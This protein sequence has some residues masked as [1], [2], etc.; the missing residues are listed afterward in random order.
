MKEAVIEIADKDNFQTLVKDML[1]PKDTGAKLLE[2]I[3]VVV[4]A[5][6][7]ELTPEMVKEMIEKI[8]HEHLGWLVVWGG[9]F[10]GIIGLVSVAI[11]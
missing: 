11:F 7:D 10:G 2:Q 8:I 6:L 4:L 9:F 5:R 1:V 3:E